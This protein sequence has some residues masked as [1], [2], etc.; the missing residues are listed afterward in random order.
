MRPEVKMKGGRNVYR[1]FLL[2]D[3]L[4]RKFRAKST[5]Y[6]GITI[7]LRVKFEFD[8]NIPRILLI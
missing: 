8:Q 2:G 5:Y 3:L 1:F 7:C 6:L 4:H